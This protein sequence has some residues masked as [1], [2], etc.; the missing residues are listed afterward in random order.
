MSLFNCQSS[1]LAWTESVR[2]S[3]YGT[4]HLSRGLGGEA[5]GGKGV[6][7]SPNIHI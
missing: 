3:A 6:E 2:V 5:N 4:L 7:Q 1:E